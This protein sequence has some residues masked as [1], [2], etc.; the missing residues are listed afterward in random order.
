MNIRM[1]RTRRVLSAMVMCLCLLLVIVGFGCKKQSEPTATTSEPNSAMT[2]PSEMQPETTA[3]EAKAPETT[4]STT[5][6]E[7]PEPTA[8]E[9][10]P[11]AP[12]VTVNGEVITERELG[13]AVDQM[14]QQNLQRMPGNVP[15][16][17]IARFK[18]QMRPRILENLIVQKVLDQQVQAAHIEVTDQQVTDKIDERLSSLPTPMTLDE[19]KEMITSKGGNFDEF[20][21]QF[22]MNLKRELFLES[23]W[24]GKVD[25]NDQQ[26][27]DYYEANMDQFTTPEKVRASHILIKPVSDPNTDPNEAKAAARAKI[28]DLLK[29]VKEGADFAALAQANSECPSA[30]KGGDLGAFEQGRMVKPFSD[31]AFAMEPNEVSDIVETQFGYHIIKV[32]DRTPA[33]TESLEEAK[34]DIKENLEN[35]KKGRFVQDFL[36]SLQEKA[37]IVYPET[38]EKPAAVVTP[39]AQVAPVAPAMPPTPADANE[40]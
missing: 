23:Q 32:T 30:E 8:I 13:T 4:A 34:A 37:T 19:C 29:Q 31:A 1:N 5:T 39:P 36:K 21:G 25:V 40:N 24:A 26:V 28:D 27:K 38:D 3:P 9:T 33:S 14:I 18:E 35:Q 6:T 7:A 17:Q 15:P 20:R 12:V 10:N 22:E 16:E 11:N 2:T